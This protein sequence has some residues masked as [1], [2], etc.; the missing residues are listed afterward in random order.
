MRIKMGARELVEL[1]RRDCGPGQIRRR[2]F[3]RKDGSYVAP[4]CV[5]DQGSPGKTSAWKRVLPV[6]TEGSLKGWKADASAEKRHS[7]LRKA[8]KSEGCRSV[9][10]RL[11]LEANYTKK[12]S[13]KT[14]RT[15]RQ[16]M[17]WVRKQ[18]ICKLKGKK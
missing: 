14:H 6:P 5:Q 8:V 12:T 15:A 13:P 16:D 10:L 7:S 3:T 2:G 11:N 17:N 18:D 9:I 1:G 4:S